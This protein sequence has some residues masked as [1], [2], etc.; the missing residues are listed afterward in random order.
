MQRKLSHITGNGNQINRLRLIFLYLTIFSCTIFSQ[1]I[2]KDNYTGNW[3]TPT[4]WNPTWASPT[5]SI[6][7]YDVT[8]NG[9]ITVNGSLSFSGSGGDLY[10][11]DTLVVLGDLTF[12]SNNNLTVNTSGVLIVR[13]NLEAGNKTDILANSYIVVT[14]NFTASGSQ[15]TFSSPESPSSVFIGGTVEP[16]DGNVTDCPGA[17]GYITNCN[18]GNIDEDLQND[19]I[20]TFVNSTCLIIPTAY[21]VTGGGSYCEGDGGVAV[22]LSNSQSGVHYYL[23]IHGA[24][25]GS[26]VGGTGS[27]ISFGNQT[28]PGT[29]TVREYNNTTFC[30]SIMSGSVIVTMNTLPPTTLI[31]HEFEDN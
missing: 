7:G 31:Y 9:Y 30:E 8:I 6:S 5:I 16:V 20:S 29:Y 23:M 21:N 11:N 10:I 18:Y 15:T 17:P 24:D 12:G 2:S 19:P 3:L 1:E 4:S 28:G 14:G 13:G 27:A 25:T 26:P 22:G